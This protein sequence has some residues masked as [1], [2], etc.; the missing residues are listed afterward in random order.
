VFLLARCRRKRG[1]RKPWPNLPSLAAES[2]NQGSFWLG[3]C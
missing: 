3:G 1:T 2:K